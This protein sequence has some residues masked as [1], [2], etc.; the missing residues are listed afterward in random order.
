MPFTIFHLVNGSCALHTV[1][2]FL[3]VSLS[4]CVYICVY[5]R[6]ISLTLTHEYAERSR[7]KRNIKNGA[8]FESIHLLLFFCFNNFHLHFIC[9]LNAREIKRFCEPVSGKVAAAF[10]QL[11]SFFL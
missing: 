2:I 7:A 9:K 3:D 4:L 11:F 8:D 10:F 1:Y 6:T 5:I